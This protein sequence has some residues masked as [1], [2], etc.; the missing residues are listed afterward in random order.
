MQACLHICERAREPKKHAQRV[1][2]G[3]FSCSVKLLL[4]MTGL[5]GG[6]NKITGKDV[7]T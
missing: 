4:W 6:Y 1:S 2:S 3:F 5:I 7:R